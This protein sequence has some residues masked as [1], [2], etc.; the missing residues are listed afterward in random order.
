ML[1][2]GCALLMPSRYAAR[3]IY[4]KPQRATKRRAARNLAR[5]RDGRCDRRIR[6]V[7][8]RPVPR[9]SPRP[10]RL[11]GV[12]RGARAVARE[13][14]DP[15]PALAAVP[16]PATGLGAGRVERAGVR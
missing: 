8:R 13:L 9:Q 12:R 3:L 5:D 1:A 16:A 14:R 2:P 4:V 11:A 6:T 15:L 7:R 10:F